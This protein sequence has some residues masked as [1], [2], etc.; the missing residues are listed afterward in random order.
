LAMNGLEQRDRQTKTKTCVVSLV[1]VA[2]G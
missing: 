1:A 2:V